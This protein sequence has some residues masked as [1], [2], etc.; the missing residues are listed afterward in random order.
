M[1]LRILLI[2]TRMA[3]DISKYG[4]DLHC[5]MLLSD[6]VEHI[7]M[8]EEMRKVVEQAL[9]DMARKNNIYLNNNLI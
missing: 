8:F 3:I 6:F 4:L 9:R 2:L 1:L 7:P 5:E